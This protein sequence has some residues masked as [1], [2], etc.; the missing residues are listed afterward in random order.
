MR[1]C[2]AP[3]DGDL[4]EGEA[5]D[6]GAVGAADAR[7][8]E[9]GAVTSQPR[10]SQVSELKHSAVAAG[11]GA[12]GQLRAAPDRRVEHRGAAGGGQGAR[13]IA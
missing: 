10:A 4:P 8:M 13:V 2:A 12:G 6:A 11:G 9:R 7:H 1:A 3:P 5:K